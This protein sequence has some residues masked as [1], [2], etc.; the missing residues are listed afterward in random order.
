MKIAKN[1]EAIFL[2]SVALSLGTGYAQAH[3]SANAP[4]GLRSSA[5]AVNVPAPLQTV[6]VSAK[7]M[8]QAEK[9]AF[10]ALN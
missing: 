6:T 3:V 2:I 10:D 9:D 4:Q 8:S 5:Q 1:M 7:R